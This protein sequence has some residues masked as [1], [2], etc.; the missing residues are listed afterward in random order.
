M[1]SRRIILVAAVAAIVA[2]SLAAC[3]TPELVD[4]KSDNV[5]MAS[6]ECL[7]CMATSDVPGPGCGD[8]I[9]ECR[10][11][12][13]CS[14]SYD[15]ALQRSCIGGTVQT[16]VA[17]LPECTVLAGLGGPEDPGR[18]SGIR[19]FECI[20]HGA[21]GRVCFTDGGDGGIT[22]IDAGDAA[23]PVA[24]ASGDAGTACLDAADQ[25][26]ASDASKTNEAA[27]TCGVECYG[28]MDRSCAAKCMSR[29]TGF[30]E[31]CAVCW[32]E[33]I[34][35]VSDHCLAPCLGGPQDQACIACQNQM[36]QPAFHAC[37]GT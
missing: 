17:C 22:P 19:V 28:N 2:G 8:E 15:C 33:S 25:A 26:I 36:C 3:L 18:I 1:T 35:C 9:A 34:N 23:M 7:R 31:A 11:S 21:C 24:D 32:G 4:Y 6:A 12:E 5:V 27:R 10:K 30:T 14:K 16:L 13:S 20:T 37:S 29:E